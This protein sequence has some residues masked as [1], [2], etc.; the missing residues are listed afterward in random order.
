MPPK[1]TPEEEMN[2]KLN[3]ILDQLS[4]ITKRLDKV[5]L[6]SKQLSNIEG[7]MKTLTADNTAMKKS[8]ESNTEAISTIQSNQ[9]RMDQYNRS[10]SVRIMELPLTEEEEADPFH[11][12]AT[13]YEKVFLP[14]LTGAKEKK[15]IQRIPSCEQLLERAHVLPANKAGATKPII[16]RFLN[17][18]YRAICFRL[19]KSYATRVESGGARTRAGASGGDTGEVRPKYAFPFYEDP[20]AA[21]FKKLK[22][23]QADPRVEACW[24]V[25]GLL[26]YRL[27]GSEQVKRVNHLTPSI[28]SLNNI[29]YSERDFGSCSQIL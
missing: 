11:L 22:E 27:A 6:L 17:R 21:T 25:N 28:L 16:C 10:W 20:T 24:S 13:V 3:S 1:R 2:A 18:D 7:S 26:R 19:K 23:L 29:L 12:V 14:L 8:I 9:N 4:T 5:D 15:I